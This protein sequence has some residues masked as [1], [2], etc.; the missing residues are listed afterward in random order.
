MLERVRG[1]GFERERFR[2]FVY[3]V[4]MGFIE[5]SDENLTG[6][7]CAKPMLFAQIPAT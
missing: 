7:N 4:F 1:G 5:S 6:V 3:E 2:D